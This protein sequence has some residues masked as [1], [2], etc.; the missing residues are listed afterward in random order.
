MDRDSGR[1]RGFAFVTMDSKGSM[2]N[3]IKA[4]DG[5]KPREACG[6]FGV[7][8][9]GSPVAHLTYLGIYALQ[10]RGQES[11][12]IATSD[13]EHLTVVKDMGLVSN[14]F[15]DRTLAALDGDLAGASA[16]WDPRSAIGV[17]LSHDALPQLPYI[18]LGAMLLATC[19]V[20]LRSLED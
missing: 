12:G 11:A 15:D 7:H 1:P 13:G 19:M 3:A 6:V 14:V 16:D 10:H 9:P 2:V 18:V 20:G 4:L 5:G 17:V 8:A